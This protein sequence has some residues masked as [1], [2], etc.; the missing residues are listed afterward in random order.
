MSRPAAARRGAILGLLLLAVGPAGRVLG[1]DAG[2]EFVSPRR[3]STALGETAI[4]L[5]VDLP[6]GLRVERIVVSADGDPIATLTEPPWT[7]LWDA[8]DGSRGHR[9]L[10]EMFLSDGSRVRAQTLTSPLRINQVE[11]VGLVNLY[12]MVFDGSGDYVDD[13][14]EQDFEVLEDG[15]KQKIERFTTEQ[16]PLRIG[17]VLDTSLTMSRSGKLVD[18]QKAAL[19]FLGFLLPQDQAMVVTFS[20]SVQVIQELTSERE[21]LAEAIKG[22]AAKG[23]TA[24]Y[25]AVWRASKRLEAFEGRRVMILLSDGKDEAAS[26]L[27]PG[28]LHTLDEALDQALRSEVMVFAIGLGKR[29]D[30]E[31]AREWGRPLSAGRSSRALSLEQ[32]LRRMAEAT[33]GRLLLSPSG[34]RLRK[35]FDDVASDLRNQYSIAYAPSDPTRDGEW[36]AVEVRVPGRDLE[37]LCREG[38]YATPPRITTGR[39][40][41]GS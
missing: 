24:L 39:L 22:T 30:E 3:L 28:S 13:L 5:R 9:L 10:A 2:L 29:L 33:G 25:D 41:G 38:Y 14:T 37:I 18:A 34:R 11:E 36:R 19:E 32:I 40:S 21:L 12:P 23:G 35:A 20:D 1:N 8:G 4:E 7:L 26:G 17:I 31:Y 27:E 15:V 6:R 16:K